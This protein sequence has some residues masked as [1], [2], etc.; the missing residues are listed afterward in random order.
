MPLRAN[1]V[2]LGA[3]GIGF[4]ERHDFTETDRDFLLALASVCAVHLQQW[5]RLSVRIDGPV[6]LSGASPIPGRNHQRTERSQQTM[7]ALVA[8][9][10]LAEVTAAVFHHGLP[11]G[12]SAP[13][14]RGWPWL[15]SSS[16]GCW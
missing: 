13:R 7:T 15:I 10:S 4:A 16:P 1:G 2:S 14:R 12:A 3:L 9:A 11:F 5:S 6:R 8:S